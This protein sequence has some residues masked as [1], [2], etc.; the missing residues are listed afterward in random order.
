MLRLV[1]F[2]VGIA[3]GYHYGF[4]DSKEYGKPITARLMDRLDAKAKLYSASDS[5][6][7]RNASR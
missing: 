7:E 5:A 2:V 3:I 4:R 1:I 6:A